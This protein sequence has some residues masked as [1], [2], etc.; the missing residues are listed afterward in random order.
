[1]NLR[2]KLT[3]L[4]VVVV[5]FATFLSSLWAQQNVPLYGCLAGNHPS[6]DINEELVLVR[7]G[8]PDLNTTIIDDLTELD[9]Q[10]SVVV[11]VYF[12]ND[13]STNA[14]FTPYRFPKFIAEDG[15]DPGMSVTG[16]IFFSVPLLVKEFY[17]TNG[18]WMS[19]PA[20]LA[21]EFAHAMQ[22]RNNSPLQGM[23]SELHADYM[24]GWYIA[25]RGRHRVQNARQAQDSL[26]NKGDNNFF[27]ADHHGTRKQRARAFYAGYMFNATRNGR[28]EPSAAAAYN[29]GIRYITRLIAR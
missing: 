19:V 20:I 27:D 26:Y 9:N 10:F 13:A 3:K 4:T 7:T 17:E 15:G 12:L 2:A 18:S 21:H 22:Y 6:V 16:T 25:H 24:A 8:I 1:M 11:P 28:Y 23:W 14:F 5:I 29:A